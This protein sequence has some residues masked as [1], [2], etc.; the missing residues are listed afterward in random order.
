M[1]WKM[2]EESMH[3]QQLEY[4]IRI[5]LACFCGGLIGL[6]RR[7]RLKEAGLRTHIILAMGA[8][9]M[10]IVSKYGFSDVD[11]VDPSRVAA[12][13]VTG[14]SFLGAGVIFVRG[15]TIKGLTTAA[16][17]W[18]TA[19]IGLALGSGMYTMGLAATVILILIQW[20]LHIFAPKS[21]TL[22]T[23]E[24]SVLVMNQ[25]GIVQ[26]I[27]NQL[28]QNHLEIITVKTTGMDEEKLKIIISVRAPKNKAL[29]GLLALH[30]NRDILE[31]TGNF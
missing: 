31:V 28:D 8:A 22:V 16:G 25:E 2:I 19:G 10:V 15:G 20:I 9:C 30:H 29:K 12:N 7:R 26:K 5:M 17:I 27:I 13:V 1:D 24:L 4:L 21:E 14:V 23:T 18:T 6:E 3:V 11:N